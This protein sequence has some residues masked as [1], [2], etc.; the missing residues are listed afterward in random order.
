MESFEIILPSS[1]FFF[2]P[3]LPSTFSFSNLPFFLSSFFPLMLHLPCQIIIIQ[4]ND[5]LFGSA[6]VLCCLRCCL[7]MP[8]TMDRPACWRSPPLR[9]SN[10]NHHSGSALAG[11]TE[12]DRK[13]LTL[14]DLR[15]D[16]WHQRLLVSSFFLF[17]FVNMLLCCRGIND[18]FLSIYL[19]ILLYVLGGV[20]L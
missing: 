10:L 19:S 20:E 11:C 9:V 1:S 18:I 14:I 17:S 13:Q 5:C 6:A 8:G 4:Y 7:G 3:F 15:P 2:I 16:S 12:A